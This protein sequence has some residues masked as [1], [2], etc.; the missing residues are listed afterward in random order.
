MK[1]L[2]SCEVQV[3]MIVGCLQYGDLSEMSDPLLSPSQT[4]LLLFL[5]PI[6]SPTAVI[7]RQRLGV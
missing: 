6:T 5:V 4:M 2:Q 3:E 7:I 1:S